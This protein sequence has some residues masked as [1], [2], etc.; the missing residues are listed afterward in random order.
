MKRYKLVGQYEI[1]TLIKG[2]T[3]YLDLI[4]ACRVG[5]V[6]EVND[7]YSIMQ[8]NGGVHVFYLHYKKKEEALDEM[9]LCKICVYERT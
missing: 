6:L 7:E 4:D 2:L 8:K 3:K 5:Y 9:A 1:D